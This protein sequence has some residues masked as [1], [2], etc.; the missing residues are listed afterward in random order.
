MPDNC[1][2]TNLHHNSGTSQAQRALPGLSVD[3]AKVDERSTSDLLL[4]AKKY[5]A[6]LNYY[7]EKNEL[8]GNW[9]AFMA[10]DISVIIAHVQNWQRQGRDYSSYIN[11]LYD[12]IKSDVPVNLM[13]LPVNISSNAIE[14]IKNQPAYVSAFD[15]S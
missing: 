9:S 1:I 14:I 10:K 8:T 3:Y 6:Y 15:L 7:N 13:T 2:D 5:G 11:D 4:F 12:K